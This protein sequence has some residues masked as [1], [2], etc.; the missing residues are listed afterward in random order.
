MAGA[1]GL[2]DLVTR[3]PPRLG[4]VDPIFQCQRL[5]HIAFHHGRAH[6]LAVLVFP[7]HHRLVHFGRHGQRRAGLAQPAQHAPC[8][9]FKYILIRRPGPGA[10][11]LKAH[12]AW[13]LYF[14]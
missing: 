9:A 13:L 14:P 10:A 3:D 6:R 2:G 7:N 5:R 11:F 1:P 8:L 4:A 12:I